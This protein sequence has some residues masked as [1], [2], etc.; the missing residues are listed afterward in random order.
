MSEERELVEGL[1]A[2]G[3]RPMAS[4]VAWWI[5]YAKILAFPVLLSSVVFI[6]GDYFMHSD[7]FPLIYVTSQLASFAAIAWVMTLHALLPVSHAQAQ[8]QAQAHAHAHAHAPRAHAHAHAH[9]PRA[10]AHTHAHAHAHAY[11]HA[12]APYE[13]NA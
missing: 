9:A 8:A 11:A 2:M 10:H 4:S 12:H 5:L 7:P 13:C 1:K 6:A 3:L